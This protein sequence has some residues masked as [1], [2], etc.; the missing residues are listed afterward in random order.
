MTINSPNVPDVVTCAN[1]ACGRT[2]DPQRNQGHPDSTVPPSYIHKLY[3]LSLPSF[4]VACSK[5][6]HY[7][8]RYQKHRPD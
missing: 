5:C 6:G 7:S 8:I 3:D 2:L 1:L 4:S